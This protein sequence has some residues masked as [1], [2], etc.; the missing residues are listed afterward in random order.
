MLGRMYIEG[1]WVYVW[2]S[3]RWVTDIQGPDVAGAEV[4]DTDVDGTDVS[5]AAAALRTS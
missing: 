1:I 4:E 2:G 3:M 5:G